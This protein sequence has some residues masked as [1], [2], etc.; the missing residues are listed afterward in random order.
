MNETRRAVLAGD[1]TG[2]TSAVS[3]MAPLDLARV[4]DAWYRDVADTVQA[5]GGRVVKFIGD[6]FFAVFEAAPAAATCAIE[7]S[8]MV[9]VP[10]PS[11]LRA[12]LHVGPVAE[13]T[14]GGAYDVVGETVNRAFFA[15]RDGVCMTADVFALVPAGDRSR[16]APHGDLYRLTP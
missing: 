8:A 15:A 1:L 7:L 6:G 16:W 11:Q 4:L 10:W 9:R 2:Y 3:S 14:L 12:G 5:H 13:G